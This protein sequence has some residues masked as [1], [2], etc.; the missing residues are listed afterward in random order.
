M[1]ISDEE[2]RQAARLRVAHLFNLDLKAITDQMVFGEYLKASF[3][4]NFKDNEFNKL[5]HDIRDVAD[6]HILK[7][8]S[9][10]ALDIRTVGDYCEH[11][12]RCYSAKP[13]DVMRLLLVR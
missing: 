4:S 1:N 12:V 3:V 5:D 10:G 13:E 2:L 11:M 8:L 6:H 7:K 9:S